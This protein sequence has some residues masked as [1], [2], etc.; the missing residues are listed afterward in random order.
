MNQRAAAEEQRIEEMNKQAA[1]AKARM[2]EMN[3]RA[4]EV[5]VLEMLTCLG[6]CKKKINTLVWTNLTLDLTVAFC[7]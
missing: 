4:A 5:G 7:F 2:E 3:M 6:I 1:A